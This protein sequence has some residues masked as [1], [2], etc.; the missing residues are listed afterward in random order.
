MSKTH[1]IDQFYVVEENGEVIATFLLCDVDEL[2]WPEVKAGDSLYIHKLC[3]M[4][5]AAKSLASTMIM[6]F[7]KAEG[8]RLNK[9]AC[10]LDCRTSKPKL[11]EFYESHGFQL[12]DEREIVEGYCTS[13]YVYPL[14]D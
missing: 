11:K 14:H 3:V 7:F 2:Y 10:R 4:R 8:R 13:R 6:D 12:V 9:V 5:K 1:S